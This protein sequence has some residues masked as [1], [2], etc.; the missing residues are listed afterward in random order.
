MSGRTS[1]PPRRV[2]LAGAAAVVVAAIGAWLAWRAQHAP[3]VY[4]SA[5]FGGYVPAA[6]LL[7]P[8]NPRGRAAGSS[9]GSVQPAL[10]AY[11]AGHYFEA[12]RL[13][14]ATIGRTPV[15]APP[16]ERIERLRSRWVLAFSAA[17]RKQLP[18]ARREFAALQREA[19]QVPDPDRKVRLESGPDAERRA[20]RIAPGAQ[21]PTL[22][23]D[24][25]YQ[26]A[27]LT[28][29]IEGPAKGEA[30]YC[31][32]MRSYPESPLVHAAVKRIGRLHDGD[33]PAA[34]EA[35]W[36]QAMATAGERQKARDRLAAMCGPACLTEL[37]GR[38]HRRDAEDAEGTRKGRIF[39]ERD[40]VR[41]SHIPVRESG[42]PHS[43]PLLPTGSA[44]S[45]SLRCIPSVP[46]L[47]REMKTDER[48][49]TLAAMA[50]AAKR[51]GLRA[52]G[53]QLTQ[54]GLLKRKLPLIALSAPGHYVL[55]EA[56]QA[57]SALLLRP[58]GVEVWDP[59]GA[60]PGEPGE[61]RY[62]LEEWGRLWTGMVLVVE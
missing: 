59:D 43:S 23:E 44:S 61:R 18:Q 35:V 54:N 15:T 48:G 36:K 29:A 1:T 45:A 26:H 34:A 9:A 21:D 47:A 3:L 38:I 4:T 28:A 50:E 25:A 12:G 60:G 24:A 11:N 10:D 13:A 31:A 46:E 27:V 5:G 19:A 30:E 57:P 58:G 53:M 20:A 17:R 40:P 33:I 22:E 62:S 6:R 55:V 37:L 56:V 7:Q 14:R 8:A 52:R 2:A 32:F 42:A 41:G 16:A 39:R 49:T 51:R